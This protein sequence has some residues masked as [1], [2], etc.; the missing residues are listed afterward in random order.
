MKEVQK[1]IAILRGVNVSGKNLIKMSALTE[2]LFQEGFGEVKSYIQSGNLCFSAARQNLPDLQRNLSEII[3]RQFGLLVP[4]IVL[5]AA[6]LLRVQQQN[7]FLK[8]ADVNIKDLYLTFLTKIPTDLERES[9]EHPGNVPDTYYIINNLVFLKMSQG[10]GK[11][12]FNNTF[13]EK[14]LNT[15]ATTRNWKTVLKLLEM[16]GAQ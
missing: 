16:V 13:F 7:P 2:L 11:T 6:D 15:S 12:K 14:K 8:E 9:L 4:V 10:Y 3:Y 1:Y 5:T